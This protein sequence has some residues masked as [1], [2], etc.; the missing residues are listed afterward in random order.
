MAA[1]AVEV[2]KDDNVRSF[3]V[4]LYRD[5][6]KQEIVVLGRKERPNL[7]A[8]RNGGLSAFVPCRHLCGSSRLRLHLRLHDQ[9]V[10]HV[11]NRRLLAKNVL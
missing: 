4:P 9:P 10:T 6:N 11:S 1:Q 5:P 7:S 8:P 2:P 3:G